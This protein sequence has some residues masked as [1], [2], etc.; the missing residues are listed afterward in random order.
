MDFREQAFVHEYIINGGNAYQAA[1]KAGY[2][3]NTARC[4]SEWLQETLTNSDKRHL[5]YKPEL[6]AAIKEEHKKIQSEKIANETEIREYLT[7]VPGAS[8]HVRASRY[9]SCNAA[10]RYQ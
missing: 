6:A 7:K 10:D 4:A 8:A 3:K 1:L 2:T 5:P 9:P